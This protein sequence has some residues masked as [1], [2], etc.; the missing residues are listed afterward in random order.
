MK[1]WEGCLGFEL[2]IASLVENAIPPYLIGTEATDPDPFSALRPGSKS[3]CQANAT[4]SSPRTTFED[5]AVRLGEYVHRAVNS[6]VLVTDELPRTEARVILYDDDPWNQTPADNPQWL[7]MFK[8]GYGLTIPTTSG[9]PSAVS[10]EAVD[11]SPLQYHEERSNAITT[12]L[13]VG[14]APFTFANMQHAA[15]DSVLF[16]PS[17]CNPPVCSP[18]IEELEGV[19]APGVHIPWS[20][21]TP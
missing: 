12:T 5:L 4:Q 15:G 11:I 3:V 14:I 7:N 16:F 13:P 20:W 9:F 17:T 19:P 2:T 1:E 18:N 8:L 10:S 6:G 21:Q